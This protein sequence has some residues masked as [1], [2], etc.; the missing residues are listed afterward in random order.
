MKTLALLVLLSVVPLTSIAHER[1]GDS[2]P[3]LLA[4]G[5][6]GTIGG[7]IGPDGAVYVP[8][9]TLGQITRI[10]PG[11]GK[12]TTFATGLPPALFPLSG[13]IDVAFIG[14]T[15]YALVT[16]VADDVGGDQIDGIYRMDDKDHFTVI[17]DLGTFSRENPPAT[18]FDLPNGLQFALEPIDGGFLVSDGH[19]NRIL[20]VT[21]GGGITVLKQFENVVPT[22]L[23][24]SLGAVFVSEVGPVPH[25]PETGKVVAFGLRH[26]L[27]TYHIAS[28][29]SMIVDV[30]FGGFGKL[31][32]LSQGE[33]EDGVQPADAAKPDTGKL[34]RVKADGTFAVLSDK[35]DR[36]SSL[37]LVG[38]TAFIVTLNGEVWRFDG[39]SRLGQHRR[40]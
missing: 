28:G 26:P 20:R 24:E 40:R 8:E 16:L 31:Y 19:H 12:T 25:T 38:D 21:L 10:A 29:V 13:A 27:A 2:E 36:P 18:Q 22:G 3:R 32:A 7:T 4:S 15:A 11:T 17:A 37:D 23:A 33:P 9:A 1:P 6:Q 5:L 39:V 34:L 14:N 35:I 30:E